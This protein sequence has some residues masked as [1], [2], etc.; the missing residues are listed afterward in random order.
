M[1]NPQDFL[2]DLDVPLYDVV[3]KG[4]NQ[5]GIEHRATRPD[6]CCT[7]SRLLA[8]LLPIWNSSLRS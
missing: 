6:K 3:E 1:T 5:S 8:K 7:T 4:A 2:G